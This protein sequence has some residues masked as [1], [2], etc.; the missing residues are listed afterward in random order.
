MKKILF[1]FTLFLAATAG[2]A[3]NRSLSEMQAIAA[4]KLGSATAAVK[5]VN[6]SS[7][8]TPTLLR[9][10]D[11]AAYSIFTPEQGDG[12]VIVAKSTLSAPVIGYS[13]G[14]YDAD[15]LPP[16]FRWYLS[17]VSRNL[18]D[19]ENGMRRAPQRAAT[20]TPVE[21][22]IT[23]QWSQ[24]YP[25]NQK[26]PNNYPAGCVATALAQCLNY[27]QY[28][29]SAKF[30][31]TYEL[32]TKVGQKTKTERKSEEVSTTYTWPYKDN[33]KNFGKYG[34]NIDELLRDCGY[35]TYMEYSKDGSG[36]VGY[37]VGIALTKT[38]GYPEESIKLHYL[39]W[40]GY[41]AET[42]NQLI[43]DELGRR[44]PVLYGAGSETFGG[45]AFIFSGID[46]EG[47]VYVNW[48]WRGTADGFFDIWLLTPKQG[49]TTINFDLNH[50]MVYGIRPTALPT[51][52]I[53][54]RIYSI[55]GNAFTFRWGTSEDNDGV[56]H[57]TLY[58]DLPYGFINTCPSDFKGV[59][60]IFGQDLTDGTSWVIADDLQD[61]DT[62]PAG[63]GY[64]GGSEQYKDFYFYYWIDGEKGLK[65][66]HTYH[67][68]FGT[69]DDREGT[70]HSI[71]GQGEV[72]YKITYTGD[73]ATSTIEEEN[74]GLPVLTGIHAPSAAMN[75]P[76]SDGLTRVFDTSGRLVYAAPDSQFNLWE[77]PAH[78]ILVVKQGSQVRKVVR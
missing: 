13:K 59:F 57:N 1:S 74:I 53:E 63:Y 51:D 62:I 72:G 31:G 66:G 26:T 17:E 70:W 28:P 18:Q 6:G 45:H 76:G 10:A 44:C 73:P 78:G 11:D 21:N 9:V 19:V 69:K 4:S 41:D 20:Y 71:L 56:E 22:F 29:A 24:E 50:H 46:D 25:F 38:F 67:M 8:L 39:S 75:K 16:A 34:D 30:T 7:A 54:T 43:Y 48:G 14:R 65:P 12:F 64:G 42:W 36:T 37:L 49:T 61:R 40:V 27:Y 68:S 2:L 58:C 35:A 77:V 23:T 32:T 5:G 55:S 3:D 52:R 47:K 60:G 15:N 33:Y